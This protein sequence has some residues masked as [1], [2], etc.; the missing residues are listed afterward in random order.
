[1]KMLEAQ[2]LCWGLNLLMLS[3]VATS[4][5]CKISCHQ[6]VSIL[7]LT[8]YPRKATRDNSDQHLRCLHYYLKLVTCPGFTRAHC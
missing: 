2:W 7:L 1:M 6:A 5:D 3:H 4:L 8:L